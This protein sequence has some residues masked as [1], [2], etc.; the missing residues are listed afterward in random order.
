MT[1]KQPGQVPQT[2]NLIGLES[3][4]LRIK[5]SHITVVMLGVVSVGLVAVTSNYLVR[6]LQVHDLTIGAGDASGESYILSQ[7]IATVIERYYPRIHITI[8]E[9][10]GTSENLKLLEDKKLDLVTAQA[11]VP[12]GPSAR[13]LAKL[14]G[15]EFQLMVQ[16]TARIKTFRDLRGKRIALPAAGGQ[17][18]SF[19]NLA[20][21]F[22]LTAQ[23]FQFVGSTEAEA[24]QIFSDRQADAIFRVRAPSNTTLKALV[25]KGEITILPIEQASAM[26]IK[27]PTFIPSLIAQGTYQGFPPIPPQD[28]PTVAVHRTLLAR[29][30]LDFTVVYAITQVLMDYRQEIVDAIP[31]DQGE[32]RPLVA[33]FQEPETGTGLGAPLH[34]G[35]LAYYDRDRP[36]FIQENADLLG[37]LLT[38]LLV[39]GSWLVQIKGMMEAHQKNQADEY[40]SRVIILL[41][42]VQV[43][44]SLR[45]LERIRHELLVMLTAAVRDLDQDVIS[46]ESFQSFRVVWQIALDVNRERRTFLAQKMRQSATP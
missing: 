45:E 9:T 23:D 10:G 25:Q 16:N 15:D 8:Q 31:P 17:Y 7:A 30:D 37:F 2:K 19:L 43:S 44:K 35:A 11:D 46:E 1:P 36:S 28:L 40:S 33:Q 24:N 4:F 42:Q 21:H 3:L 18:R 6:K 34:P 13:I 32:I 39:I 22:G 29:E 26:G 12:A 38:L 14:Y 41:E 5:F 27:Y 20:E